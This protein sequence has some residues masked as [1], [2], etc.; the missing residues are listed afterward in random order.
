MTPKRYTRSK[1]DMKELQSD[2][3]GAQIGCEHPPGATR[4]RRDKTKSGRI[5]GRTLP[6][7]AI[8]FLTEQQP[9]V[10]F[11]LTS[12]FIAVCRRWNMFN[13]SAHVAETL[14]SVHYHRLCTQ[15]CSIETPR[16]FCLKHAFPRC[17]W[18]SLTWFPVS[19]LSRSFV[20]S[21][22]RSHRRVA[23]LFTV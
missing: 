9:G 12:I 13:C 14:C 19:L 5:A 10:C 8:F 18:S 15:P 4:R 2:A 23:V 1:R 16:L 7:K 21:F 20:R 11:S 3:R 22:V 6:Y 17:V